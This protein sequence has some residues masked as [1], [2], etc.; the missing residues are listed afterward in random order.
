MTFENLQAYYDYLDNDNS[1]LQKFN[2]SISLINLRDK[3]NENELKAF[4]SYELFFTD[5]V[6]N[7]GQIRPKQILAN[8]EF[9][10]DFSL[11]D[12]DFKYFKSRAAIAKNPKY[13]AKYNHLLWES[14][15]KHYE[16]A[17]LA[18]DNYFLF[19]NDVSFPLIDNLSSHAFENYFKNL[20]TLCQI[21]NYKKEEAIQF[22]ISLLG[23]K[24]INGYKEYS[25]MR[26]I[27]EEGKKIENT[28]LQTFF[29]NCNIIIDCS[30]YPDFIDEYLQL[31]II[32]SQKLNI[33][34]K[35]FHN[36]LGE[37][38]ISQ[39]EKQKE[40]FAVHDIY[41]KALTYYQ[42]AG[43]K[44]KVEEVTV[45]VEK[46]KRNITFKSIRHEFTDEKLQQVWEAIIKM[47]DELTEKGAS[48]DIYEYI[49][50]SDRI[51]PKAEFLNQD[52]RP[53]MFDLISVMNFDINKN[54]S[55]KQKSGINPYHL[56]IQ[57]FSVQHLW[58]VF[59]KGIRNGKLSFDTLI[60]YL[61]THSWYGHNFTFLN[62]DGD[63][64][65]FDWI[66]LLSP[67]L[68]NFFSQLEID[69]KLNKNN[70]QG[71]ILPIDSLVL[72]FEGLLREFS[73]MTGAQTI[74]IKENGTEERISFEKLLDN[75]K[76]IEIIPSND[77]ALLKFLFTSEGM[78]LRNNIAHCFYK[79]KSYSAGTMFL[80]IAALLRL[81][82]YKFKP[83]E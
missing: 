30:V 52:V 55:G 77:I 48:T 72:K 41:L 26:F 40:S 23:T 66:E 49:I 22:L 2:I 50:L 34:P 28:T 62:A 42:K 71:Y 56:H 65:G 6:I 74:E 47:T 54:V 1:L 79:T 63:V 70:N 31:L 5:Y 45:L 81:G 73:R 39:T 76:I 32:L 10:P 69:I 24:K 12:D 17:K 7:G 9:Y 35:S 11:F 64:E 20:F 16:Y 13:K 21:I 68:M 61:K 38:H 3:A 14:K 25:L 18:I 78:N 36:K 33:S 15:F 60:E 82:N 57:N 58:L 4:C 19:L 53:A 67:S 51:F 46:A 8:G 75:E 83:K 43:N 80:L 44:E 59:L 37:F 27:T 29:D